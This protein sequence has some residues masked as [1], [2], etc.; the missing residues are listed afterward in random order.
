METMQKT[1]RISWFRAVLVAA[2]LSWPTAA[3]VAEGGE[4]TSR[5]K[6]ARSAFT[7][8]VEAREP[9]DD[10]VVLD[11]DI[12]RIYFFTELR[13]L[14]GQRVTHQWEYDGEVVA[15]IPFNVRGPRW[16]V[17]SSKRLTPELAGKWTV[18]VV[19]ETGW[20]LHAAIFEY[21]PD[22][23]ATGAVQAEAEPRPAS[24][25]RN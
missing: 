22:G 11:E 20:P 18:V 7:T 2:A 15:E 8:A 25:A 5:G 4:D 9:V 6:V 17:Y 23:R 16:R 3:S 1:A 24:T 12:E 13:G 19:D 10:L 14:T 21:R